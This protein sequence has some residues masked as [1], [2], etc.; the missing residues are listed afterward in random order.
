VSRSSRDAI[1]DTVHFDGCVLVAILAFACVLQCAIF[2]GSNF[3]P[4][5][6]KTIAS[7]CDAFINLNTG[8]KDPIE[9]VHL[10]AS[11]TDARVTNRATFAVAMLTA[12]GKYAPIDIFASVLLG[13]QTIRL[14]DL[15]KRHLSA[16]CTI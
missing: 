5:C 1:L 16:W 11:I 3:R 2:A 4:T 7:H 14:A 13:K 6:A 10:V 9:D 12:L 15:F 8:L